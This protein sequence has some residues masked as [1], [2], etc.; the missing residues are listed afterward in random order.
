MTSEDEEADP[1]WGIMNWEGHDGQVHVIE[2]NMHDG[3][4]LR[5]KGQ[6]T[7]NGTILYDAT[8]PDDLDLAALLFQ[9]GGY[10]GLLR[11]IDAE[12]S[13][14]GNREW[15]RAMRTEQSAQRFIRSGAFTAEQYD[16]LDR[17]A[18]AAGDAF[19]NRGQTTENGTILYDATEPEEAPDHGE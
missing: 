17:L 5:I 9:S 4:S 7:K 12:L 3:P 6:I 1:F 11:A 18:L 2:T 14:P 10:L 8:R 16:V 19:L 15:R 13:V